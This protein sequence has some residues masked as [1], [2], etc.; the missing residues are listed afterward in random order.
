M[1]R[2][3][4]GE[5]DHSSFRSAHYSPMLHNAI[6]AVVWPM[7]GERPNSLD[8]AERFMDQA[9][10]WFHVEID[11]ATLCTISALEVIAVYYAGQGEPSRGWLYFGL[12]TSIAQASTPVFLPYIL[13]DRKWVFTL[14]IPSVR[15]KSVCQRGSGMT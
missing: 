9:L 7:V 13:T 1:N 11:R 6:L 5:A 4:A 8:R 14:P 3:T 2:I 10:Q 12:A 15:V